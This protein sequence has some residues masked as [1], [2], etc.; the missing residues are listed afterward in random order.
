MG[1]ECTPLKLNCATPAGLPPPRMEAGRPAAVERWQSALGVRYVNGFEGSARILAC[2]QCL[3]PGRNAAVAREWQKPKS[4][5][6]AG[7]PF[8]A[9]RCAE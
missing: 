7:S 9:I 5:A 2:T 6:G 8:D 4:V 3:A 1:E